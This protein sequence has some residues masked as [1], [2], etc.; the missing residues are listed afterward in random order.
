[1][2]LR[3]KKKEKKKER[4]LET[5]ISGPHFAVLNNFL[6]VARHTTIK[7]GSRR[8]VSFETSNP[9]VW[10]LRSDVITVTIVVDNIKLV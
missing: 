5:H 6:Y 4:A 7:R 2:R 10:T 1:M 3:K 9:E 8:S